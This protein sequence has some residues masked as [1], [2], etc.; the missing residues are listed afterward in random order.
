MVSRPTW[1]LEKAT[2][3]RI[4]VEVCLLCG[5][6][7]YTPEVVRQFEEIEAKLE[8]QETAEFELLGQSFQ[9]I[10]SD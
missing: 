3:L 1:R 2:S 7:L 4:K 6:Q 10:L 9:V 5:E 8:Y